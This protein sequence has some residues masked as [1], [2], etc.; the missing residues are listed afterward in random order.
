MPSTICQRCH[1]PN[2]YNA[3]VCSTCGARL[4]PHCHLVIESPNASICPKCGKKDYSFKPGKYSGTTYISSDASAA[5]GTA[6]AYCP[7]CGSKID[8]GMKKCPYCGRLGGMVTPTEHP[9]YGM[10][11]QPEPE[12]TTQTQKICRKCGRPFPPGS[13]QCPVHGKYGGGSRLTESTVKLEGDNLWARIEEKRAASAAAEQARMQPRGRIQPEQV[14]HDMDRMSAPPSAAESYQPLASEPLRACPSCGGEVPDRSKVCP[15][16][17]NNRLPQQRGKPIVR[18]EDYYKAH[19]P[20]EQP[21]QYYAPVPDPYYPSP[22][23][24][25][26]G[27]P[28]ASPGSMAPA[29]LQPYEATYPIESRS[30]IEDLSQDFPEKKGRKGKPQQE[31]PY[32]ETGTRKKKS[33]LPILL[34]LIALAGIIIIAV[35][36]IMD[37]MQTPA[38]VVP[39]SSMNPT[40]TTSSSSS[41]G[42]VAISNIEFSDIQGTSAVVTWTTDRKANSIVIY[43]LEGGTQCETAKDDALVTQHSVNLTGMEEGKSY[44]ITVKSRMGDEADSPEASQEVSSPLQLTGSI[45]QTAPV[46]SNVKVTN[47]VSS[48]TAASAEITWKTDEAAT[49]QVSY[50]TSQSYG[51]LQPA[52]TDTSMDTFHDVTLYGLPINATIHYKVITRDASGN[53]SSSQDATF[54]TPPPAGSATGNSA[55]DFTLTCADGKTITL[56]SLLG[57]KVIIN[58]WHLNCSPCLSE[59]PALQEMHEKYPEVP[60]LCIHGTALGSFND[61]AVGAFISNNGY[62]MTIPLDPTGQVSA[63]YSISSIP[64]TFFLDASGVIRKKQDGSFGSF[65]EI[66]TMYNSY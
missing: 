5:A 9:G 56:S 8:P 27:Q 3:T 45:D 51:S 65:S 61:Y 62:T 25:Y 66:E 2:E 55:P 36:L 26:Y 30:F 44:H 37:Q 46:I 1:S 60:L 10:H 58:F 14:Y 18:A 23:D 4:C 7:N 64:Q 49:S 29:T 6:A 53:E 50:G 19:A 40:S 35:M 43:C 28:A 41:G 63:S 57:S 15:H 24:P 22:S 39:P 59:M 33:P 13:S 42:T 21:S 54:V 31:Q 34:A 11:M 52:Q 38:V 32:R 47:K 16:C 48:T 17:G 12:I 20:S